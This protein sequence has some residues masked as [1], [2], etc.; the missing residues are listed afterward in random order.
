MRR[1]F[2]IRYLI[3]MFNKTRAEE[4]IHLLDNL[5]DALQVR[6]TRRGPRAVGHVHNMKLVTLAGV[7]RTFY[8]YH[9][10]TRRQMAS[11]RRVMFDDDV[12]ASGDDVMESADD[13]IFD[14]S[15][16]GTDSEQSDL[17]SDD[18]EERLPTEL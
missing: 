11:L 10:A 5:L 8:R 18:D 7:R 3:L 6:L 12:M 4:Q 9:T 14:D 16:Y 1:A 17:S 15:D 2:R 13:V